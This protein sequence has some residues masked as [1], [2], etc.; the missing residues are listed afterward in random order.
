M[1]NPHTNLRKAALLFRS[2]DPESAAV[3][4]AQLSDSEAKAVRMAIRELGAVDPQEQLEIRDEL[5][6]ATITRGVELELSTDNS[7]PPL[8][9]EMPIRSPQE[10][11][12]V[13]RDPDAPFAWLEGGDLP[14]LAAVLQREHLSTV[15]V[16][17]SYLPAKQAGE[18]LAAL[19]AGR[20]AAAL[21]R[22]ADLGESDRTSLEVIEKGLADWISTRKAEL[23][24]RADR[25]GAVKSILE[26]STQEASTAVL[27]EIAGR[28]RELANRLGGVPSTA[29]TTTR[30]TPTR[31][32]IAEQAASLTGNRGPSQDN[33]SHEDDGSRQLKPLIP[34]PMPT[35]EFSQLA[36]LGRD[37]IGELFQQ[38]E[39]DSM[40]LA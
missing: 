21:E 35:F 19:P 32:A 36:S 1:I 7:P 38:C 26:H 4:L 3:L 28:D 5:G 20:R 23:R 10:S 6:A 8:S 30:S 16:V 13:N 37:E 11:N 9:E 25:L 17:L 39:A 2:L 34:P 22:L 29:S 24:R 18:L 31:S 33:F 27:A 15:A 14:S 40:V 12:S